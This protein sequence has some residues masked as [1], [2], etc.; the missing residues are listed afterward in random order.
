MKKKK[1]CYS[2]H[3][4]PMVSCQ[5]V[6]RGETSGSHNSRK[7]TLW[8]N[9]SHCSR[10]GSLISMAQYISQYLAQYLVIP[11]TVARGVSMAH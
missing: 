2:A 8:H 6:V 7:G 1:P 3:S 9:T 4:H 11:L 5:A 10:R